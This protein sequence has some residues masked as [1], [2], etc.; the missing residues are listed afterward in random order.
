M[1]GIFHLQGDLAC[2]EMDWAF[3]KR[4]D[5]YS[6]P[7]EDWLDELE[8]AGSMGSDSLECSVELVAEGVVLC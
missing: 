1:Q 6:V 7:I 4:I 5:E 8:E 3:M 2:G